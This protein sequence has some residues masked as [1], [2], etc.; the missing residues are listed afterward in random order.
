M[1]AKQIL[2]PQEKPEALF[3]SDFVGV[4]AGPEDLFEKFK[5]YLQEGMD[6]NYSAR[7]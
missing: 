6:N 3:D 1:Y 2:E 4:A 7:R 5:Q